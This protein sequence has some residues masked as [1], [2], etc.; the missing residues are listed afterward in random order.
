MMIITMLVI[1]QTRLKMFKFGILSTKVFRDLVVFIPNG[2][3][4][5]S[6]SIRILEPVQFILSKEV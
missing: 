3:Q 5:S 4:I 6:P 2:S 1:L